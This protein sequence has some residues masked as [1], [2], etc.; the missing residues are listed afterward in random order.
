[1][2]NVKPIYLEDL[3]IACS[4]GL[5]KQAIADALFL[6]PLL[7]PDCT[8]SLLSGRTTCVRR[9]PFDVP[10]LSPKFNHFNSRNN[11]LLKLV[12]DEIAERVENAVQVFGSSRVGVV[13]GTST[14][15]MLEGERGFSH[16]MNT[17]VWPEDYHYQQQETSSPSDFASLY[18]GISGPSY[19]ISTAC[20]SGAKALCSARRLI[21]AGICDVVIAGAVDTL[22]NLTL[23]GFDSLELLSEKVCS[24]FSNNRNGITLGEGAAVFLVTREEKSDIEFGGGGESS[25]AYHISAPEPNG[26]GAE[27][28][29]REALKMASL[30]PDDIGYINLHGTATPLNDEMESYCIKRVFGETV[31]CSST[32]ALTG[33]TLGAAGAIEAGFLW[34]ALSQENS[35][36]I[37]LPPH[38]WDG[39]G[40]P[41]LPSILL[42]RPGDTLS[43]INGKF[44]LMSNSFAFGGSNASLI[45]SKRTRNE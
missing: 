42:A 19:T 1:M 20:S 34:M 40:D 21:Q 12:L 16:K 23:N 10:A 29:M 31:P 24:P 15:G 30:S 11:S 18:F 37:P 8:E 41:S 7:F 6:C 9:V 22:C 17:G 3:G 43:P 2:N 5:G 27:R 33:H 44:N 35:K 14:S 28:A 39:N 32:K 13:L 26:E 38:V 45:F 4:L 36:T 25:D